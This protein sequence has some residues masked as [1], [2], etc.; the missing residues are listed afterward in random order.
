MTNSISL[1]LRLGAK[2]CGKI[3]L[4]SGHFE[5]RFLKCRIYI[6]IIFL[7]TIMI[8]FLLSILGILPVWPEILQKEGKYTKENKL[9]KI[10]YGGSCRRLALAYCLT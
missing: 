8:L 2:T 1:F 5:F 4:M 3:V 10:S 9:S 6:G 7:F